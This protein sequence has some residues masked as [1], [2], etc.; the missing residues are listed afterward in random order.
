[1]GRNKWIYLIMLLI[2][3]ILFFDCSKKSTEIKSQSMEYLYIPIMKVK[4]IQLFSMF[5]SVLSRWDKYSYNKNKTFIMVP[6]NYEDTI[7]KATQN[8]GKFFIWENYFDKDSFF[9]AFKV[10]YLYMGC[11]VY[12][13]RIFFIHRYFA[14]TNWFEKTIDFVK[15]KKKDSP[16]VYDPIPDNIGCWGIRYFKDKFYW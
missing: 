15:L 11:V 5:D 10:N 13:Q 4:P 2:I 1:M 16:Q 8:K 14:T 7:H 3:S 12:K 9:D 6:E